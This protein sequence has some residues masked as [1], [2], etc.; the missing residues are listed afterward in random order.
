MRILG[1]QISEPKN[2]H[3]D[4]VLDAGP[5]ALL[6]I[7][8]LDLILRLFIV[9]KSILS[10]KLCKKD[11]TGLRCDYWLFN[12]ICIYWSHHEVVAWCSSYVLMCLKVEVQFHVCE[13]RTAVVHKVVSLLR[14]DWWHTRSTNVPF[15]CIFHLVIF[16]VSFFKDG[17]FQLESFFMWNRLQLRLLFGIRDC[18]VLLW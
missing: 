17:H 15:E 3:S 5:L 10:Q 2:S 4:A 18:P 14:L 9:I 12:C 13:L 8:V 7:G 16:S 1:L 11:T 6:S